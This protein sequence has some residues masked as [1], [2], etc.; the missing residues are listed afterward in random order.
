MINS[1]YCY[2]NYSST[3]IYYKIP[4]LSNDKINNK[5]TMHKSKKDNYTEPLL[6]ERFYSHKNRVIED[7]ECME[8]N[9]IKIRLPVFPEDISEN[10]IKFIINNKL[11]GDSCW[12]YDTGDLYSIKE[13]IQECKCF[14]SSG[15]SSFS[16]TSNWDVI[17]FLD[18]RELIK[19]SFI[20]YRIPLKKDSDEWKKIK[21]NKNETFEDQCKAKRRPRINWSSLYP[22]ISQYCE[23]VYNGT[24]ENI[25]I[26]KL[27]QDPSSVSQ[28]TP[29]PE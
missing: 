21:M 7:I 19:D 10:V 8:K 9:K 4:I 17:Y 5:V 22:Q 23:E 12:N 13:G 3:D 24:F 18:G 2:Y 27:I 29:Q 1:I 28:S 11:S 15:P 16:P 25:F 6:K 20:L 14:T 26:P